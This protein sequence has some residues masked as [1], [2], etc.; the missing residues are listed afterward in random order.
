MYSILTL[1][2]GGFTLVLSAL[3]G[4]ELDWFD[5]AL[6][7]LRLAVIGTGMIYGALAPMGHRRGD[8]LDARALIV[9]I[10]PLTIRTS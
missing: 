5:N 2:F 9:K 3:I 10:F 6:I 4:D 7:T 8:P 1:A